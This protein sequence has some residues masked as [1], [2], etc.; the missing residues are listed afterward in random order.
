MSEIMRRVGRLALKELTLRG[1]LCWPIAE[2]PLG[3]SNLTPRG[4]AGEIMPFFA[5]LAVG[6]LRRLSSAQRRADAS[7]KNSLLLVFAGRYAAFPFWEAGAW[8]VS[9]NKY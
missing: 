4:R 7:C 8:A 6:S 3:G 2:H 5:N 9:M 1:Q